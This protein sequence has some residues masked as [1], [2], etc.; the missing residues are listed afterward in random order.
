MVVVHCHV[1]EID[2]VKNPTG[3]GRLVE[4]AF[5]YKNRR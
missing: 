3:I 4:E 1:F 5:V 2:S